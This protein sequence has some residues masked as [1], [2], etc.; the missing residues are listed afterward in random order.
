M[1]AVPPML[2]GHESELITAEAG[3]RRS[4]S[5]TERA[6][7]VHQLLE[8]IARSV[9]AI[10]DTTSQYGGAFLANGS[11]LYVETF[12]KAMETATPEVASP[13]LV[14]VANRALEDLLEDAL[15]VFHSESGRE[16]VVFKSSLDPIQRSTLGSHESYLTSHPSQEFVPLLVPFLVSREILTGGGSVDPASGRAVLSARAPFILYESGTE[17]SG[18]GRS[19]AIIE[20]RDEPLARGYHR[21]HLTLG[22]ANRSETALFLRFAT[23]GAVVLLA[24]AILAGRFQARELSGLSSPRPVERL[25]EQNMSGI[26]RCVPVARQAGRALRGFEVQVRYLLAC[27]RFRAEGHPVPPWY[28][29]ALASWGRALQWLSRGP[30]A[31]ERLLDWATKLRLFRRHLESRKASWDDVRPG[32]D[33]LYEL[34]ELDLVYGLIGEIS[35]VRALE[36][37]GFLLRLTSD[38]EVAHAKE[39]PP[40]G[41]ASRA[42]VRARVIRRFGAGGE[43]NGWRAGWSFVHHTSRDESCQIDDPFATEEVWGPRKSSAFEPVHSTRFVP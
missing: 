29:A 13:R 11:R 4:L 38:R 5:A 22:A 39:H 1:N 16:Y 41:C 40:E 43:A 35:H 32:T 21:L 26:E 37:E 10:P 9:P 34:L 20:L 2:F 42:S 17:M 31:V 3:G 33:L 7:L 18:Q 25:H 6:R 14:V 19:R 8:I 24:E 12:G 28:D 27:R 23:T 15:R 36:R 30:Q